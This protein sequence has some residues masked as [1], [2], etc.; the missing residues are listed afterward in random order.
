MPDSGP[1]SGC[2]EC[3][4]IPHVGGYGHC[5]CECHDATPTD[6]QRPHRWATYADTIDGDD[7]P[8]IDLFAGVSEGFHNGPRCLDCGRVGCHHCDPEMYQEECPGA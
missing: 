2:G 6:P 3:S 7:D 1:L 5:E 8:T 4:P